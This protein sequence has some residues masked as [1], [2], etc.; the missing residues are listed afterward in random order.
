MT[1]LKKDNFKIES[2]SYTKTSFDNPKFEI[3][4][5][6]TSDIGTVISL[7]SEETGERKINNKINSVDFDRKIYYLIKNWKH[8]HKPK[9][10]ICD[11]FYWNLDIV[12]EDGTKYHFK[13][14]HETP[15]NF[16][17]FENFLKY[18]VN[19]QQEFYKWDY[20]E[21]TT[22]TDLQA[23]VDKIKPILIGESINHIFV[24]PDIVTGGS[25]IQGYD[26]LKDN[27][28]VSIDL[29]YPP[30]I[31]K[32]GDHTF[33]FEMYGGSDL[34]VS[35]DKEFEIIDKDEFT[36]YEISAL[37]SKNIIHR[38]IKDITIKPISKYDAQASID[39]YPSEVY[40]DD[41]FERIVFE[42]ENGSSL[43][44]REVFDNT[45]IIEGVV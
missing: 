11:S 41:M 30:C 39:W 1:E 43:I 17:E 7:S 18:Q 19:K 26:L 38:K 21:F 8:N 31:F 29:V 36:Y 34:H 35:L 27:E 23:Y 37:F 15:D 12:L 22:K 4:Y 44:I 28:G 16:E 24:N 45:G 6:N 3:I 14:F 40:S 32:I 9:D 5:T 10:D 2:M 33:I 42:L 13:G 20:S 25:F